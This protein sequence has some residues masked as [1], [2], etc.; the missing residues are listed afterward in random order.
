M[1]EIV[2]FRRAKKAKARTADAKEADANRTK[3]GVPKAE[4][5]L[6][7]ARQKKSDQL[8]SGH[9]LAPDNSGDSK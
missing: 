4:R 9:K 5:N 2:N 8:L 7:K 1:A 6:T 3:F